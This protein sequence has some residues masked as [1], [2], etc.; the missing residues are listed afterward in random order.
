MSVSGPSY[1]LTADRFPGVVDRLRSAA[2]DVSRRL[3][4]LD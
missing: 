4:H 3:G 1:R 2:S